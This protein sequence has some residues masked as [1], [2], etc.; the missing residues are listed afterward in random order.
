MA[1]DLLPYAVLII[2]LLVAIYVYYM[3][4]RSR[5]AELKQA[6]RKSEIALQDAERLLQNTA[7]FHAGEL[8]RLRGKLADQPG[9]AEG[10]EKFREA[11]N[12]FA[13]RFHPDA[14]NGD[15]EDRNIRMA[16]FQEYWE[17]LERIDR[18]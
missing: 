13:R 11:K 18:K 6:L 5:E 9:Y 16:I 3:A 14:A 17:V 12:A 4:F 10:D 2:L 1:R 7:T 15:T 8:S